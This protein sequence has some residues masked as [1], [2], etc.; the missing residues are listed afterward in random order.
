ML[1]YFKENSWRGLLLHLVLM[2]VLLTGLVLLFFYWYLPDLTNHGETVTV[3]DLRGKPMQEVE[4]SLSGRDLRFEVGDSVYNAEFEPG[5]VVSHYPE[6]NSLVKVNRKIY[7]T[8]NSF[9]PP[10]VNI[11]NVMDGSLKSARLILN[12]YGLALGEVEYLPSGFVNNVMGMKLDGVELTKD[13]L[14]LGIKVPKGT[15]IDLEVGA[16]LAENEREVPKL[17]GM[18]IEEAEIYLD[19]L[20]LLVGNIEFVDTVG[21][22]NGTILK[23]F[24]EPEKGAVIQVGDIIDLWIAGMYPAEGDSLQ[25]ET[26][27]P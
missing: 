2:G 25:A 10:M 3:P 6:P 9:Q 11:P 27:L 22:N 15:V 26:E 18:P 5:S 16:G 8:L 23:Q 19:G 12:N 20:G 13:T 17:E 24:P 7:L 21:I 4:A 14:L 1:K